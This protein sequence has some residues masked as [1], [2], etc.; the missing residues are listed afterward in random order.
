MQHVCTTVFIKNRTFKVLA[1]DSRV[2]SGPYAGGLYRVLPNQNGA[3][4]RLAREMAAGT[5][6][7]EFAY[8]VI[9]G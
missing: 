9:T 6:F 2:L 4:A 5:R 1:R 3:Y 7:N 8:S